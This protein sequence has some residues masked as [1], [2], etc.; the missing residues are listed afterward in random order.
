MLWGTLLLPLDKFLYKK[1]LCQKVWALLKLLIHAAKLSFG[2]AGPICFPAVWVWQCPV[3]WSIAMLQPL[4]CNSPLCKDIVVSWSW[5]PG[6]G[7]LGRQAQVSKPVCLLPGWRVAR[8]ACRPGSRLERWQ[9]K[10][11][12]LLRTFTCAWRVVRGDRTQ[13]LSFRAFRGK[14]GSWLNKFPKPVFFSSWHFLRGILKLWIN[15]G[16]REICVQ[17]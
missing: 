7:G 3:Y 2:K 1:L 10:Q 6:R 5:C 15:I 17:S 16:N 12:E 14:L 4:C 9:L 11:P 13:C 8:A